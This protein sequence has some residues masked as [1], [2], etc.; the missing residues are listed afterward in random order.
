MNGCG[1]VDGLS[2]GVGFGVGWVGWGKLGCV[3][4]W[5]S[6]GSAVDVP[7]QR[8]S[9]YPNPIPIQHHVLPTYPDRICNVRHTPLSPPSPNFHPT[10]LHYTHPTL[11]H[12]RANTTPTN[13]TRPS[14]ISTALRTLSCPQSHPTP[15]QPGPFLNL[16]PTHLP[17]H[18][19]P[20]YYRTLQTLTLL[21]LYA[22]LAA[23]T[24]IS[25]SK[26]HMS[27]GRFC[28]ALTIEYKCKTSN[29]NNVSF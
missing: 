18:T 21:P 19:H 24:L 13:Q 16:N 14:T 23:N 22:H 20:T 12:S 27:L 11:L 15:S 29:I 4:F 9:T 26:A 5:D 2:W 6:V 25:P 28:C 7:W 17:H 10:Y 8:Y 3:W 1:W